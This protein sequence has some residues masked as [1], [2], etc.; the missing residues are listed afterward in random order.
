VHGRLDEPSFRRAAK[1]VGERS[2]R[3]TA[4]HFTTAFSRASRTDSN[5]L[6]RSFAEAL[7][8]PNPGLFRTLAQPFASA[9]SIPLVAAIGAGITVALAGAVAAAIQSAV[10]LGIGGLVVGGAAALLADKLEKPFEDAMGRITKVLRKAAKPLLEPLKDAMAQIALGA[11][12]AAPQFERIFKAAAPI[13]PLLV[14]S[15]ASFAE[16]I[17][18]AIEQMMPTI[19]EMFG[20]LAKRAPEIADAFADLLKGMANPDTVEAF[21]YLLGGLVATLEAL[22]ATLRG[23]TKALNASKKGSDVWS[24]ALNGNVLS[25]MGPM[26]ALIG[27]IRQIPRRWITRYLFTP[28]AAIGAIL[29][30]TGLT[31]RIPR[32]WKTA[33]RF[34][35]GG[36]IGAIKSVIGWIGRIPRNVTTTVTSVTRNIVQS[37]RSLNPFARASGGLIGAQGLATGGM[38][39]ARQVLVG[40]RGPELVDLPFG[41]RV[42]S[43]GDTRRAVAGG[44]SNPTVVLQVTPGGSGLD[45]LFIDWLRKN[46]RVKGGN[47]QTVLGSG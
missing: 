25:T 4:T 7:F 45:A 6:R 43:N 2:G 19:V 36:A 29:R 20:V 26:G 8:T 3:D 22:G 24:K 10:L 12:R 27:L 33:Y 30:V 28:G 39:G 17:L 21:G 47:V 42:R 35:V 9:F 41:S 23:L 46:V 1:E 38:S 15:F 44:Q 5:R 11:E 31:K 40:E 18:P 32:S 13:V 16:K 37:I 34:L 14:E